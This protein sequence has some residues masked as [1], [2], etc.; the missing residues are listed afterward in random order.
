MIAT[1]VVVIVAALVVVIGAAVGDNVIGYNVSARCN[2]IINIFVADVG[3]GV[4]CH[5]CRCY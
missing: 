5:Y 3:D 2:Y 4:T 1:I